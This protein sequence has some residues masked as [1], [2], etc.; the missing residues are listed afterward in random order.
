MPD[1]K[2]TKGKMG[3][4]ELLPQDCSLFAHDL[5][6]CLE[7]I[8]HR[9]QTMT[10]IGIEAEMLKFVESFIKTFDYDISQFR[11]F[12]YDVAFK[13]ATEFLGMS[14]PPYSILEYTNFKGEEMQV[15]LADCQKAVIVG[16]AED[17][18]IAHKHDP[19]APEDCLEPYIG[20]WVKPVHHYIKS[21]FDPKRPSLDLPFGFNGQ[22]A[23]IR[24]IFPVNQEMIKKRLDVEK[25]TLKLPDKWF[26][27]LSLATDYQTIKD[28]I[29]TATATSSADINF[30][31]LKWI[32]NGKRHA[33]VDTLL[34]IINKPTTM[35]M[36]QFNSDF[37]ANFYNNELVSVD[38]P[39]TTVRRRRAIKL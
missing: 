17:T 24:R 19:T 31:A 38:I 6:V 29:S 3:R 30:R 1:I 32:W 18:V 33:A 2:Y 20:M 36:V 13:Q 16:G 9:E 27:Q 37:I 14:I 7:D 39:V 10:H 25:V 22:V 26:S 35:C 23:E 11:Y 4:D 15:R 28:G 34:E 21:G 5:K 12:L 8:R